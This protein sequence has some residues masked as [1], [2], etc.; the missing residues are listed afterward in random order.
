MKNLNQE[1]KDF[2]NDWIQELKDRITAKNLAINHYHEKGSP[3][4]G[5]VSQLQA[6][7]KTLEMKLQILTK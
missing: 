3:T 1:E 4:N 2:Y 6:E 5:R 7:L